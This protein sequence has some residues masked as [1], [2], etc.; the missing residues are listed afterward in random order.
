[1]LWVITSPDFIREEEKIIPDLLAAGADRV[2]IRK[3]I[4]EQDAYRQLLDKLPASV[5]SKLLIRNNYQLAVA[6]KLAG[7]HWTEAA[8]FLPELEH[9]TGIHQSSEIQAKDS[10][11][12]TLLLSPV[13]D[14]ISKTGYQGRH[15]H[16]V[17]NHNRRVLA[18][19]GI[20]HNNISQ[21]S[22][23]NYQGAAL[24]GAIWKTPSAAIQSFLKIQ[25][26]WKCVRQS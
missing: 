7:C 22:S 26:A 16:I 12:S 15:A 18:M 11:F 23:W 8:A 5:Y 25:Q 21:L 10:R 20:D 9:S 14:S 3:P 19:G 6:Y 1:M 4:W 24:L 17:N 13:F 2:L